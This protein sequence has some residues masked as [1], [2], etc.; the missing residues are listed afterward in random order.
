MLMAFS[1]AMR[2]H[3]QRRANARFGAFQRRNAHC[4]RGAKRV[5]MGLSRGKTA[6]A[7]RSKSNISQ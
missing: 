2:E 4:A 5:A 1:L 7:G 3:A 6:F